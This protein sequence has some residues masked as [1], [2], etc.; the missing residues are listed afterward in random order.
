MK[1]IEKARTRRWSTQA[2]L[3]EHRKQMSELA[4]TEDR[5]QGWR[6]AGKLIGGQ[7]TEGYIA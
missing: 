4:G 5:P 3:G 2:R 7:I 1:S 6:Q